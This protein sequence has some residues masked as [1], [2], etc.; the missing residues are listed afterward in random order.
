LIHSLNFTSLC[1]FVADDS[2]GLAGTFA[3]ARVCAGALP[4]NGQ[5][6]A[7]SDAAITI[8]CL[9]TLEIALHLPAQIAFNR[10][11]VARDRVNDLVQLLRREVLRAEIRI[12]IR[13]IEN[14][15]RDRRPNSVNISKR[16][17]DAFLRRYFN[18]Q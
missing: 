5:P 15:L 6:T 8:D 13:L 10:D 1:V 17:L 16:R 18:S 9:Q 11:L 2:N 14:A 3:G 7:M 12:D 4:A